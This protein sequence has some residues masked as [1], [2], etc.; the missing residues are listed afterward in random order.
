M[1]QLIKIILPLVNI[2]YI[3]AEPV[4]YYCCF[5]SSVYQRLMF[6]VFLCFNPDN[7]PNKM[8]Q[9]FIPS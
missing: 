7:L 2:H 8:P 1:M 4:N 5:S 9:T 3:M 6:H